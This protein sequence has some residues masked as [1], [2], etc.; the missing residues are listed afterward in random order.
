M[1]EPLS[2]RSRLPETMA[3]I[4][5]ALGPAHIEA[6]VKVLEAHPGPGPALTAALLEA[7]PGG[8]GLGP[9]AERLSTEWRAAEPRPYGAT[10]A[11][12]LRTAAAQ[13][14]AWDADHALE[15]VISGPRDRTEPVR[16]TAAVA[17]SLIAGAER[18]ILVATYA[19]NDVADITADLAAAAAR[20]VQVDAI[21]ETRGTD[22]AARLAAIP[23][24]HV[25]H[26]PEHRRPAGA[27]MHAKFIIVDDA[28]VLLGSANLTGR[29]LGANLEIGTLIHA[30]VDVQRLARHFRILMSPARGEL[31]SYQRC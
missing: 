20:A 12:A 14:E 15:W 25:W 24:V 31:V 7:R 18:T 11:F 23:G 2:S 13:Y 21:A 1:N 19:T 9:L 17:S 30:P 27:V 3:S 6:W 28:K 26:W 22:A 8:T 4:A 10:L 16:D 29:A 5:T